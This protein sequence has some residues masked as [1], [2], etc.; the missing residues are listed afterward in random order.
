MNAFKFM[1]TY[2]IQSVTDIS[3][4]SLMNGKGSIFL[5]YK[6]FIHGMTTQ[7][8]MIFHLHQKMRNQMKPC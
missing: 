1:H 6:I 3:Y 2:Q 4:R 8:I 5:L 7:K